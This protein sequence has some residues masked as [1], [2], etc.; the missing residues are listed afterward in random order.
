MTSAEPMA[1]GLEKTKAGTKLEEEIKTLTSQETPT[2]RTDAAAPRPRVFSTSN[3]RSSYGLEAMGQ[4]GGGAVGKAAA[5]WEKK[6]PSHPTAAKDRIPESTCYWHQG[7]KNP[8]TCVVIS[9]FT[10]SWSCSDL[11]PGWQPLKCPLPPGL[12]TLA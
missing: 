10:G 12:H 9:T 1:L 3:V 4:A 5:T 2:H 6:P 11:L 7:H 8:L